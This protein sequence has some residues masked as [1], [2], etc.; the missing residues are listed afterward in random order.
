MWWEFSDTMNTIASDE[1]LYRRF[2]FIMIWSVVASDLKYT[3]DLY[4]IDYETT[5]ILRAFISFFSYFGKKSNR[6]MFFF[7][8]L[9]WFRLRED[10]KLIIDFW[11]ALEFEQIETISSCFSLK[12]NWFSF[13]KNILCV[14][15]MFDSFISF[16]ITYEY[17]KMLAFSN[18]LCILRL[19]CQYA[20]NVCIRF[21]CTVSM[22]ILFEQISYQP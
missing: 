18:E 9:I 7:C 20:N 10:N 14:W 8:R 21:F 12:K 22:T 4:K 17:E 19:R 5:T 16:K 11:M 1:M 3:K 15:F 13:L 6:F 2:I